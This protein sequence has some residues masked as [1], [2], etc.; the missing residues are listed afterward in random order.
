VPA[1]TIYYRLHIRNADDDGDLLVLSSKPGDAN[2]LLCEAPEGDGQAIDPIMGTLEMGAY[3]WQAVDRYDGDD[4]YTITSLIADEDARN[5]LLSHKC[6]GRYSTDGTTWDELHTGFLNDLKLSD[7]ATYT[8]IVGDTDRRERDAVLFRTITDQFNK[9]SNFIGGPVEAETPVAYQGTPTRAWGPIIDYGPARMVVIANPSGL[10]TSTNRVTLSLTGANLPPRYLGFQ[11]V[12]NG[13]IPNPAEYIDQ[14]AYQYFEWDAA[15]AYRTD[16]S[17]RSQPWGSFPQLEVKLKAVSGGAITLTHPIAQATSKASEIIPAY[18][19]AAP[20]YPVGDYKALVANSNDWLI[21]AWDVA[22]MG[23][24]PS[25]STAYDVW[26]RP[27]VISE[28]NPLH[29]RGHPI[30]LHQ[31]ANTQE[32]IADDDTSAATTK[33]ALG[34]LFYELRITEEW[35]YSAFVEM[36]KASAGYATRYNADGEQEFFPTRY[37]QPDEVDTVTAADIVG[38]D[39]GEPKEV[40]FRVSEASAIKGVDFKLQQFRL[41]N[42]NTDTAS[43]RPADGV[44][45]EDLTV[46]GERRDDSVVGEKIVKFE[47]PGMIM[48]SGDGSGVF[49]QPLALREWIIAAGEVI[50]DRAGW[51]WAEGELEVLSTVAGAVGDYI[52]LEAPHQV[53]AKVGQDPIGQRG[54][55][56]KVQIVSRTELPGTSKLKVKDAGNL[57]QDPPVAPDDG[58]GGTDPNDGI[59]VPDLSLAPSADDPYTIATVTLDNISDFDD[60]NADTL[61]QYLVQ[62]ATPASTDEGDE[63]G[64]LASSTGDDEIDA[65]AAASGE[66]IWVR[67]RAT[68]LATG[69]LGEWSTWISLT[70]GP[71][72]AGEGGTLPPFLLALQIDDDGV[73]AA[74]ATSLV[75][76]ITDVYFLAGAAGGAAPTYA[77]VLLETPDSAGPPFTAAALATMAEGEVRTVGAIGEDALGNRTVLVLATITRSVNT[78]SGAGTPGDAFITYYSGP[79][80]EI[81]PGADVTEHEELDVGRFYRNVPNAQSARLQVG[82]GPTGGGYVTAKLALQYSADG[83]ITW[84]FCDADQTGPFVSLDVQGYPIPGDYFLCDDDDFAGNN[85]LF[86]VVSYDGDDADTV[87]VGNIYIEFTRSASPPITEIPAP[88]AAPEGGALGDL[89]LDLNAYTLLIAGTVDGASV[90][91]W[92]DDSGNGNH[93]VSHAGHGIPTFSVAGFTGGRPAVRCA[94]FE[95]LRFPIP[96]QQAFTMYFV[97]DNIVTHASTPNGNYTGVAALITNSVGSSSDSFGVAMKADGKINYGVGENAIVSTTASRDTVNSWNDSSSHVHAFIRQPSGGLAYYW[98]DGNDESTGGIN[99]TGADMTANAYCYIAV[100]NGIGYPSALDCG[101]VLWYNAA[102]T[103]TEVAIVTDYLR[104]FWGTP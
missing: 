2:T 69:Q 55:T 72:D 26:V 40:I 56:R 63:F 5:Q 92:N 66:T 93:A 32:G 71:D 60:L 76:E 13:K 58:T 43:D 31:L 100:E 51:G 3:T 52:D 20:D 34:D 47:V 8:F 98:V 85:R 27:K 25:V 11:G 77:S 64:P 12:W 7:A 38:D 62:D 21:V 54:G 97:M 16:S 45:A 81:T 4:V 22:T 44:I 18:P 49:N 83:G 78:G 96:S 17:Q 48:L 33:A 87:E 84:Y 46:T 41:W 73:L 82:V 75:A 6:I 70:L 65:P 91:S 95:G 94:E 19:G 61:L 23:A 14:L 86:R 15:G 101:R 79:P 104:T 36:L 10:V 67:G 57:A 30:D 42:A 53:N 28:S 9:V 74:T 39:R 29:I 1:T 68:I 88:E 59:P 102:H 99:T 80:V 35:E 89:L 103:S 90:T 37:A 24:Q 50:I